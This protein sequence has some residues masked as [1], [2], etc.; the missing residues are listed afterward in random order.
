LRSQIE[1]FS[2]N[3]PLIKS[4]TSEAILEED[5]KEIQQLV[6]PVVTGPFERDEIKVQQFIDLDLY[7]FSEE[8]EEIAMRAEKK[9]SL[10]KKLKEMKEEMKVY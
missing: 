4:F 5:W 8:I 10:A 2:K 9:W 6:S 1:A 7:Q 3:L